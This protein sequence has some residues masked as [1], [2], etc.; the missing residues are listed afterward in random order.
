VFID[1][2]TITVTSGKGGNGAVSFRREK[3]I[4]KGGPDGG[5]GGK[6]GDVILRA[7]VQLQTLLDQ[8]YKTSYTAPNGIKGE[9][10]LRNG[11]YG[12]DL[13]VQIPCGTLVRD[14]ETNEIL[15]DLVADGDEYLAA[16][17]GRGGRGNTVFKS[18]TNQAPRYSE[19]GR[20]GQEKTLALEL[21]LIADVGLVGLPNAGKSTLISVISAAKPKIANYPFTT[22]KPNLGIVS[23]KEYKSF[24]VADIPGLIE[25]ASEGKGLGIQF[26][27]HIERTRTLVILVDCLS[28]DY[29]K[30]Y[31]VLRKELETY[32]Q[33]LIQKPFLVALSKTDTL[34]ESNDE[35]KNEFSEQ[36]GQPVY[37]FSSVSRAGVPDLLDRI[38]ENLNLDSD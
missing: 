35:K 31:S 8:R 13:I 2:V 22:L 28:E 27:R 12:K 26:L 16:R 14:A 17:G 29:M 38:W 32:S 15:A 19:D 36:I 21:K 18:S 25:G 1:Q 37:E 6:G 33:E 3:F 7:N 23:Y 34:F 10:A 11:K 24:T 5:N 30:E 4:P 20:P 9:A